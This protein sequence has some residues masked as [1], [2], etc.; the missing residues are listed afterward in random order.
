MSQ[1]GAR[2]EVPLLAHTA[3]RVW[4]VYFCG[5]EY[6]QRGQLLAKLYRVSH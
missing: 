5:S 4:K 6:V 2:G 3:G 1:V